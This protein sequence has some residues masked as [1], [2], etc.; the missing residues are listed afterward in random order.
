MLVQPA[1]AQPAAAPMYLAAGGGAVSLAVVDGQ[2]VLA[3]AQ[4]VR[5]QWTYDKESLLYKNVSTSQCIAALSPVD[6]LTLKLV[7]CDASDRYQQWRRAPGQPGLVVISNVATA[8]CLTAEGTTPGARVYQ[9]VCSLTGLANYWAAGG[10]TL[11]IISG[12]L[13]RLTTQSAGAPFAVKVIGENGQ[14]AAGVPVNFYVR[15][16][17]AKNYLVFESG[18]ETA[19]APTGTDGVAT[20]PKLKLSESGEFDIRFAGSASLDDG[21]SIAFEGS[22][23]C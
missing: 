7:D 19:S 18:A 8:R 1:V 15:S 12:N 9:E 20:S 22:C 5:S 6:G 14:P 10:R 17:R 4:D 16:A 11:A 23:L 21:N 3:D 13:Q 2:P